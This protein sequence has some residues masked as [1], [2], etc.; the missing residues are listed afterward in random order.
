MIEFFIILG[1]LI[2]LGVALSVLLPNKRQS[3]RDYADADYHI[4][5]YGDSNDTPTHPAHVGSHHHHG[6][7][8][9]HDAGGCDH[10]GCDSCSSHD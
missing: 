5:A 10:G 2:I 7:H 1:F 6:D 8:A 9:H 4:A 3:A